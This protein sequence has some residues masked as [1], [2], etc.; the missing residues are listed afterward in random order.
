MPSPWR[1]QLSPGARECW[2]M[3]AWGWGGGR[4]GAEDLAGVRRTP[5]FCS[6]WELS[7]STPGSLPPPGRAWEIPRK[8]CLDFPVA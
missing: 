3:T 4:A 6:R 7:L 2:V 5:D 1:Q 8:G